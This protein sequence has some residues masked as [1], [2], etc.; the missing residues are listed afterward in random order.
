ME[1][2]S[3]AAARTKICPRARLSPDH[4]PDKVAQAERAALVTRREAGSGGKFQRDAGKIAAGLSKGDAARP[5]GRIM[6][7]DVFPGDLLQDHEMVHLP[8]QDAGRFQAVKV[9]QLHA[10]RA[11]R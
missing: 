7:V 10:Q 5:H 2:I 6:K 8:V 3:R 11:A 4:A 9:F 1:K